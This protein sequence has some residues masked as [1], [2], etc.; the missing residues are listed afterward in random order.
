MKKISVIFVLIL[1]T[2]IFTAC[3]SAAAPDF[4]PYWGQITD[5]KDGILEYSEYEISVAPITND[6]GEYTSPDDYKL[7]PS[8][9]GIYSITISKDGTS[10]GHY[11]VTTKFTFTGK[12][13]KNG[14]LTDEFKDDNYTGECS[15]VLTTTKLTMVSSKRTVGKMTVCNDDGTLSTVSYTASNS[16][17]SSKSKMTSSLQIISDDDDI[18]K[19]CKS[20]FTASYSKYFFDNECMFVALRALKPQSGFSVDFSVPDNIAQTITSMNAKYVSTDK[21][22][23][24]IN[25]GETQDIEY[26][27]IQAVITGTDQVGA[28]ISLYFS[29]DDNVTYILDNGTNVNTQ[30]YKLLQIKHGDMIYTL[31][32]YTNNSKKK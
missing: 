17:D 5:D 20:E 11:N 15:F 12:Y 10:A 30:Y 24:A 6:K 19:D 13:N 3:A 25:G 1:S 22:S 8:S 28:P 4:N 16:Y 31:T 27:L 9:S 21:L 26:N 18:L 7:D 2:V 14:T 23:L 29:K 32:N